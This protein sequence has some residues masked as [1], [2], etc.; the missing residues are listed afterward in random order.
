MKTTVLNKTWKATEAVAANRFVCVD[1]ANAESIK[2]PM[3][4]G[5]VVLGVAQFSA[6]AGQNVSVMVMGICEVVASAAIARGARVAAAAA[7]GKAKAAVAGEHVY[8][9]ALRDAAADG[10]IIAVMPM[11][12][13][14]ALNN[15]YHV[16][17]IP[18]KLVRVTAAVDVVTNFTP[19]FAGTI[20]RVV[21]VVTDP[22]VTAARAATLNLE[23]GTT[24]VTGGAVSLTSAN[25]TPLGAVIA[26][27]AVTAGNTF[28]ASD[29]ISV[30][31]SSVTAF[32]EGEILLLVTVCTALQA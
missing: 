10:D 12:M 17:S 4:N 7:T 1:A 29:T 13:L 23:V 24:D 19:G 16:M 30:E 11:S 28:T 31:A 3:A 21:A 15:T 8:G 20:T 14:W 25:C 26:G 5:D 32:A 6:S 9:V 2:Y 22:A 18:V 27:T